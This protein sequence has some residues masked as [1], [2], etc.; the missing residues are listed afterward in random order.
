[1]RTL[2]HIR[3][4]GREYVEVFIFPIFSKNNASTGAERILLFTTGQM[5]DTAKFRVLEENPTVPTTIRY[6][7]TFCQTSERRQTDKTNRKPSVHV[8]E[9]IRK[10]MTFDV[11]Q[12]NIQTIEDL[13]SSHI[14]AV[15]HLITDVCVN[16]I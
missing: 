9:R 11:S 2:P 8:V 12:P 6:H 15:Y 16:E 10:K 3:R 14:M 4:C 13:T 1:M 5:F 7:A